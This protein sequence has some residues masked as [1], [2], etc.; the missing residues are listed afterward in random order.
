MIPIKDHNPTSSRPVVTIILIAACVLAFLWQLGLGAQGYRTAIQALGFTPAVLFGEARLP[1]GLEWV[2]APLTL[3][4]S[5]F[6]HG[7]WMHLAGNMLYLWIF[8]DNIEDE[9]GPFPF[10]LFYLFCGLIAALAQAIPDMQSQI[11]M[12]GASGAVSGVLGAYIVRYPRVPVT[13][14]I[15]FLLLF[16]M[17][18]PALVVLGLWFG[19]QLL[20]TA[21]AG[22]DPGI[23]FRAHVG[24][25][26][27]GAG[28]FLLRKQRA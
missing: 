17:R 13:V 21:A 7:G 24:G 9:L 10:V 14:V 22:N 2:P 15:P 19:A 20:S 26:I 1:L 16:T 25:F 6:L 28:I 3:V 8:G 11:P 27:A 4:T 12:I 18:V 5:M 23:A